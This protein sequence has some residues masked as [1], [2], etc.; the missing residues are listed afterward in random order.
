MVKILWGGEKQYSLFSVVLWDKISIEVSTIQLQFQFNGKVI[1][2]HSQ[3]SDPIMAPANSLIMTV[4]RHPIVKSI[5]DLCTYWEAVKS[6]EESEGRGSIRYSKLKHILR[7]KMAKGCRLGQCNGL[8]W[9][10]TIVLLM[11]GWTFIVATSSVN[12]PQNKMTEWVVWLLFCDAPKQ[13]CVGARTLV[14]LGWK[15]TVNS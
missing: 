14:P 11:M 3:P 2:E 10:G 8:S 5:I 4:Q 6:R 1:C 15:T 13:W 7:E 12:I 9:R